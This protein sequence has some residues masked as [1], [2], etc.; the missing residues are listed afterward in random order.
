MCRGTKRRTTSTNC[1]GSEK[2]Y[3]RQA[4][5][6]RPER[7]TVYGRDAECFQSRQVVL[8]G[9]TFVTGK[10]VAGEFS[11]Q[12]HHFPV[13]GHLG[14]NGGGADGRMAAVTLND[15]LGAEFRSEEHTSELQSRGHLVC[16]LLL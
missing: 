15:R 11:I 14:E 8:G 4:R 9:I 16:C 2:L 5:A 13:A 3:L 7:R 6:Y 1:R 12:Q 10:A